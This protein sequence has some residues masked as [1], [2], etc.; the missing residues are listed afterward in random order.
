MNK[1]EVVYELA[2]IT[3]GTQVNAKYAVESL[4]SVVASALVEGLDV[5]LPGIGKLKVSTRPARNGRNPRTGAAISIPAKTVVK[6]KPSSNFAAE[7]AAERAATEAVQV[8][9]QATA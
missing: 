3:G 7:L 6:F 9:I 5:S 8:E 2:Q 1:S 4:M